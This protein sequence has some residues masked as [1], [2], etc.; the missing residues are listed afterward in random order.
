MKRQQQNSNQ[1]SHNQTRPEVAM[2]AQKWDGEEI[3]LLGFNQCSCWWWWCEHTSCKEM[4]SEA[5]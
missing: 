4:L 1:E 5:K 2:D 3:P